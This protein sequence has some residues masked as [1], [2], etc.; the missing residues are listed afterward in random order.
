MTINRKVRLKNISWRGNKIFA[1]TIGSLL[2]AAA[3]VNFP[4]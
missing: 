3:P 2:R 4:A 1:A